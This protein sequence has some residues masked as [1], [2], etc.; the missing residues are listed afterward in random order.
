MSLVESLGGGKSL[1]FTTL[2]TLGVVLEFFF[3]E[4]ELLTRRENELGVTV[5]AVQNPVSK[6]HG[7]SFDGI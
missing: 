5:N 1:G 6:F 7:A 4:K 3:V 2:T